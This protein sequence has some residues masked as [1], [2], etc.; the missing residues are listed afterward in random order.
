MKLKFAQDGQ[1][2]S[3]LSFLDRFLTGA[4]R[5]QPILL[6]FLIC[7]VL[8]LVGVFVVRD[9]R[10]ANTE[11]K[12][13]FTSSIQGLQ[14][15]G[16]LQY[17]TQETRRATLYALTTNDSNLQIIYA[18]QS[19]S[20]DQRVK[21]GIAEYGKQAKRPSEVALAGRLKR[22]WNAY[23][24]IRD[25][26]LA[27][28]LEGSTKEAVNLDLAGGVPAF[29]LVRQ[30][31]KQVKHSYDEDASLRIA[32]LIAV[33]RVSS[34]KL[35]CILCFTFLLSLAA[36]WA[37]QRGQ[38]LGTMRL[39]NLQME[40]VASVSH[41]LR[42]PLAV[43]NSAADNIVD[44][45]VKGDAAIQKYGTILQNQSR[46]MSTMVDEILLFASTEDRQNRYVLQPVPIPAIMESV[47]T[48]T[49]GLIRDAGVILEQHVEPNLPNVLGDLV[50]ISHCLHNLIGNGIKYGGEEK[51]I[52]LNICTAAPRDGARRE[53]LISVADRGIGIDR[54]DL[55]H[56]FDPFYRSPRVNAAQIHGT[57][58]GLSLAKKIAEAMGG[59][60]SVISDLG[61]GSTFTLHLQIARNE[62]GQPATLASGPAT[63][64]YS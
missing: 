17:D 14:S 43:L 11:A 38:M 60:L 18:D 25:E 37:I 23:L 40:F 49:Q 57:G 24:D 53:V 59:R 45:L 50:G 46:R 35:I 16:D 33:S 55:A 48:S 26:V 21:D 9:L 2:G 19:R 54:S 61:V 58:L 51:W 31:L 8:T 20:A 29:E 64:S 1:L 30:D 27:S 62:D 41:E 6:L 39:A 7:C 10:N 56:I 3:R 28:I 47:L 52:S 15:I 36:V 22:D 5:L 42:T 4:L 44:G 32:N 34:L 63:S 12:N 13:I